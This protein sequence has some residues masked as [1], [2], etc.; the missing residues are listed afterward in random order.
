MNP[1]YQLKKIIDE[2]S[3][4]DAIIYKN[5]SYSY[6][7]LKERISYWENCLKQE[8]VEMG[9]IIVLL[10]D[11]SPDAIA[12]F[13]ALLNHNCILV[14]LAPGAQVH[15]EECLELTEAQYIAEID[16]KYEIKMTRHSDQLSQNKYWEK[17]RELSHPGLV[18]FSSGST[19]KSK[20]VVHDVFPLLNKFVLPKKQKRVIGFLLFDHIGGLNTLFYTLF[21]A[22]CFIAVDDRR[23]ESICT[24]IE[25]H[26]VNALTTTPTFL[27]LFILSQAYERHDLSSLQIINYGTEIMPDTTL[28]KLYELFPGIRFSQAYGLS[29]VGVL[30]VRSENSNSLWLKIDQSQCG[31]RVVDGLLEIKTDSSMLGYLN[32]PNPF[33]EDG[34]FKT[35]DAI[36]ERGEYF[37]IL[38]R[39]SEL[40][41][42]GGEKVYPAEV[43]NVV[44]QL[45]GVVEVVV[46]S[47]P[48]PIIGNVITAKIKLADIESLTNFRSRL[49]AFC[50]DKLAPYKIPRKISFTE[51]SLYNYR[52]KK[53]RMT[54]F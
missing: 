33:T 52:F 20:A 6:F 14:P 9:S 48:H 15:K 24:L 43:E 29:E 7:W 25:K 31:Y 16:S 30:P 32:A 37:R 2:C 11:F 54:E 8:S 13:I 44:K 18:L 40:I 22:G 53:S 41:N 45:E 26:R 23:P 38:G 10:L 46:S 17:L 4:N 19:G 28:R 49:F 5:K 12:L 50:R 21:N 42:V 39:K 51:N 34:W 3:S 1:L 27:N 35:G 47:L 36:E